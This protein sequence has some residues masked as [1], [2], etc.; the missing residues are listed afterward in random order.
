MLEPPTRKRLEDWTRIF[1]A[2]FFQAHGRGHLN[3]V[4]PVDQVFMDL[5]TCVSGLVVSLEGADQQEAVG[6]V[7]AILDD[8]DLPSVATV[9]R[10]RFKE[11][12]EPH[13]ALAMLRRE[14]PDSPPVMPLNGDDL[15]I[16]PFPCPKRSR[17]LNSRLTRRLIEGLATLI[18]A[19]YQDA[20]IFRHF[21]CEYPSCAFCRSCLE[22]ILWAA[23]SISRQGTAAERITAARYVDRVLAEPGVPRIF[24]AIDPVLEAVRNSAHH[25][26][27]FVVR[28]A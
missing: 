20:A 3:C 14:R 18:S 7:N 10:R 11:L 25:I 13:P 4:C 9:F 23:C 6:R 24:E 28:L 21:N 26:E 16:E 22:M 12:P 8:Y 15:W 17:S 5:M 19:W 2:W 27:R 1:A